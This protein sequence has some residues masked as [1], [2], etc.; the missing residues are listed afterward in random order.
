MSDS[1][2]PARP[3]DLCP[4]CA[5]PLVAGMV[6]CPA[7]EIPLA[8]LASAATGPLDPGR[9]FPAPFESGQALGDRYTIVERVGAGGMGLIYKAL[10]RKLGRTVALKLIQ[11]GVAERPGARERFRREILL[12]QQVSHPNVCR[13]H[14]LGEFDGQ[15]FISMEY[16][17]GQTLETLIQSMGHL[18]P[19]QTVA[20]AKQICAG[21][22]AIHQRGIVHRDLKPSNV[23]VDRLGHVVLMDF[24]MAYHEDQD[25][26]TQAGAVF[27]T[28]GYLAPEQARGRPEGRSDL[29]ALGLILYE[30]L[31][32]RRPP[33]DGDALPLAL[34]EKGEACP[35][36]S[37]FSPEVPQALDQLVMRCLEREP[38]RRY[39]SAAALGEVL[40]QFEGQLTRSGVLTR[41][42]AP[43]EQARGRRPA[44]LAGGVLLVLLV[45]LAAPGVLRRA[46]SPLPPRPHAL[47]V[48]SF[49]DEGSSQETYLRDALPFLLARRLGQAGDLKVVPYGVSRFSDRAA[50]FP[51]TAQELGS[52]LLLDGR[53][54][55]S[56]SGQTRLELRLVDARGASLW[57]TQVSGDPTQ[58][59]DRTEALSQEVLAAAGARPAPVRRAL[60]AEALRHYSQ[61][62]AWLE[63]WDLPASETAAGEAFQA[64]L[65]AAPD[66]AEAQAGLAR[67]YLNRF[68]SRREAALVERA[69]SAA[70]RAVQLAP[71]LPEA[72]LAMGL[73]HLWRGH[74]PQATASLERAQELAPADD[75]I[76]RRMAQAY[77][78]VGRSSDAT[79]LFQRALELRPGY[80]Q[81]HNALGSHL[82]QA[83]D[84]KA[85]EAAFRRVIEL[86][87]ESD[88]GYANLGGALLL[89][90][91]LAD[92]EP[93]LKAASRIRPT[94][95][96][97]NNL[98]YLYYATQRF[99]LAAREWEQATSAGE[100]QAPP[101]LNLGDAYRQMG[102]AARAAEAYG[103]AISLATAQLEVNPHDPDLR[104]TLA[105]ALAG[106]G[107]CDEARR[108]I[109]SVLRAARGRPE[110]HHYAAVALAVC[111]DRADA[112]EHALIALQGGVAAD[113]RTN[114]DLRPLLGDPRLRAALAAP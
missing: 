10:D 71:S 88:T 25:R 42:A 112:V 11:A 105:D 58:L 102:Q 89:E 66:F 26:L 69:A 29:Y 83:G 78:Q 76:C 57:T 49:S 75:T 23:M 30:M 113:I 98:G 82:V 90:G 5:A 47:A 51:Q 19:S 32:G 103:R 15:P 81:N 63:G 33:G 111:G 60:T 46:A 34:R 7:C 104:G 39:A 110:L 18:S 31:A 36:P 96:V 94:W 40:Q 95:E 14:D 93:V 53:L 52:D 85:A 8:D 114:P 41:P 59:L 37:H 55:R 16:V 106:T 109:R 43:V 91:R 2:L 35:P 13:V 54:T 100:A 79:R 62:M 72:H 73:V 84:L 28:L 86:R 21:L 87:P 64:A 38:D 77:A 50:P 80:W 61:G 20:L 6:I 4:R 48:L 3:L 1:S 107:R 74:T 45:V 70:E 108:E 56:G 68:N 99:D 27:G 101:F 24:G 22:A 12:A 67:A 9:Q 92:A 44:L 97:R 17:E 65:E